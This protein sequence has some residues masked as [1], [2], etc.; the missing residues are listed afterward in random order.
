MNAYQSQREHYE[1]SGGG[2]GIHGDDL[3]E[4]VSVE[5]LLLG[6]GDRTRH[7]DTSQPSE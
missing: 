2:T 3:D 1:L 5:G 6:V 7:L 4:D